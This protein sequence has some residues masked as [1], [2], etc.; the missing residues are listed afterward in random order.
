MSGGKGLPYIEDVNL[1]LAVRGPGIPKG[2][3]LSIPSSHID[4]APTLLDIARVPPED[5]PPFF[6]GR[7]LLPEWQHLQPKDV[8]D[9]VSR[10]VLSV[11]FWGSTVAPAEKWTTRYHDNTYKSLRLVGEKQGWLFNRWCTNNQTELYNTTADPYEL[12]NLAIDPSPEIKRVMDRL[13]GLLL[14]TK[15]CGQESCRKPWEVLRVACEEEAMAN[16]EVTFSNLDQ[17]MDSKYDAFFSSLPHFGFEQCLPYQKVDNEG[18]YFPPESEELGRR[19]R[20]EEDGSADAESWMT[21]IAPEMEGNEYFGDLSQRYAGPEEL[22]RSAR[23][24]T[25]AEKGHSVQCT[26]PDYCVEFYED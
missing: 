1:P 10:E 9:G 21:T 24:L 8:D 22:M 25:E 6:D 19:Y 17:A 11:E 20:A 14:V 13:S 26:E 2:R 5:W 3:Q 18:P 7:S 16:G 15:S 4:M 23:A 12:R